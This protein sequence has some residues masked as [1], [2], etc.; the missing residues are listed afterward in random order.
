MTLKTFKRLALA[1]L[2]ACASVV[3]A[4]VAAQAAP[5]GNI[6]TVPI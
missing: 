3:A 6:V 5:S 2:A 4:P 1:T